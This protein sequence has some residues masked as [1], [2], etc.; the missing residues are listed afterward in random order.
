MRVKQRCEG[1]RVAFGCSTDKGAAGVGLQACTHGFL[2]PATQETPQP[3][4][5]F[6]HCSSTVRHRLEAARSASSGCSHC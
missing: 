2:G 3:K 1:R 6:A 5:P 4:S